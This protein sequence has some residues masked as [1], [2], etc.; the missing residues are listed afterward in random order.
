MGSFC[1]YILKS[2]KDGRYYY[3]SCKNVEVRLSEH[4]AGKVKATKFRR[5]FVLHYLENFE[6]RSGAYK[7]E[8]FFK[9]IDGYK[10]LKEQNII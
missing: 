8:L 3:G 4:N 2:Q 6:T 9:T 10:W 7:R 5:P 1:S